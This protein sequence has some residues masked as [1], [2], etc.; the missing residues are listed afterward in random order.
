MAKMSQVNRNKMRERMASRD[1]GKRA[2]L[3]AIVMDRS[4]RWRTGSMLL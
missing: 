3:K 4:L 1:K 2:A